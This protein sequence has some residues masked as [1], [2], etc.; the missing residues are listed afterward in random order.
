MGNRLI[1]IAVGVCLFLSVLDAQTWEKPKRLTW[2]VGES[3]DAELVVDSGGKIHVVWRDSSQ[4]NSEI[5]DEK[6]TNGGAAW[7]GS[8]NSPRM[9]QPQHLR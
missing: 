2:N 9:E 5:Y 4:G 6:S 7:V 1:S 8:K 3:K